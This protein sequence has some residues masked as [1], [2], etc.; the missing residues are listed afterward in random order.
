MSAPIPRRTNRNRQ[1]EDGAESDGSL[2]SL[3]TVSDSSDDDNESDSFAFDDSDEDDEDELP[4]LEQDR[5]GHE[6]RTTVTGPP[7]T[8]RGS[9][10]ERVT[11]GAANN[12]TGGLRSDRGPALYDPLYQSLL[13]IAGERGLPPI[14]ALDSIRPEHEVIEQLLRAATHHT[15]PENDPT[16]A[17]TIMAKLEVIPNELVRRYEKLRGGDDVEDF[18]GCAICREEFLPEEGLETDAQK[19]NAHIFAK[20]PFNTYRAPSILAFPCPGMHLFHDYCISPWLARKTTC[21][22][23]RFD[24]D[25]DSLTLHCSFAPRGVWAPPEGKTFLNW[26]H[27]E[28]HKQTGK[29]IDE[30]VS[31]NAGRLPLYGSGHEPDE[32]LDVKRHGEVEDDYDDEEDEYYEEDDEGP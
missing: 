24:V 8:A 13:T 27:T 3:Q 26:L 31:R 2:P 11:G 12:S 16:R 29:P 14:F 32:L 30:E 28:E 18:G 21:P 6:R 20:L 22:S 1:E 5:R 19:A 4:P 10:D 7:R 15:H 9:R 25:P 23:C 17:E